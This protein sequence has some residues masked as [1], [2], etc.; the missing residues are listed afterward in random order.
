MLLRRAAGPR[1]ETKCPAESPAA[2]IASG[3]SGGFPDRG[4]EPGFQAVKLLNPRVAADARPVPARLATD[5]GRG[6]LPVSRRRAP[7]RCRR[8]ASPPTRPAGRCVRHPPRDRSRERNAIAKRQ[9]GSMQACGDDRSI[10]ARM[11]STSAGVRRPVALTSS[12][13]SIGTIDISLERTSRSM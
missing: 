2:R 10:R 6:L 12:R 11:D 4:S 8:L 7:R 13:V 5:I 9:D 1:L 3:G